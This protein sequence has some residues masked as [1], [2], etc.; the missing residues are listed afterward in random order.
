MALPST[1]PMTLVNPQN[2]AA[3]V[4]R[5]ADTITFLEHT[6]VA[7][8]TVPEAAAAAAVLHRAKAAM[9]A[10]GAVTR[11]AAAVRLEH[12]TGPLALLEHRVNLDVVMAAVEGTVPLQQAA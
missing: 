4:E 8:F 10:L 12:Q 7:R 2:L 1:A 5:R 11:Q 6:E 9:E 3:E